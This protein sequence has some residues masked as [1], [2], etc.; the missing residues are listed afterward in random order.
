MF[1]TMVDIKAGITNILPFTIWL[2][3]IDKRNVTSIP[4]PTLREVVATTPRMPGLEVH[5]PKGVYLKYPKGG[6]LTELTLTPIPV[7]RPPFPLPAGVSNGILF[8]LQMHGAKINT[9]VGRKGDGIR[10]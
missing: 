6:L 10:I 9:M 8:T 2:P 3:I 7:D 4:G 5:I 1:D